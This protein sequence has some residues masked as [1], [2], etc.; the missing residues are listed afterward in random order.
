M[1]A[2]IRPDRDVTTDARPTGGDPTADDDDVRVIEDRLRARY[3]DVDAAVI[4]A[5]VHESYRSF[6]GARLRTFVPLLAENSA[7]RALR[8]HRA[9]E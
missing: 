4:Q 7:R 8:A 5:A 9:T 6:D 1:A 3:P 2:T